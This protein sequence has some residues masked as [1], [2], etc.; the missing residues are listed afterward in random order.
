MSNSL[1]SI[2]SGRKINVAESVAAR[3]EP[4][5]STIAC[6]GRKIVSNAATES[7]DSPIN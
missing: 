2:R 1:L 3:R 5:Y 4:R 6:I 7:S